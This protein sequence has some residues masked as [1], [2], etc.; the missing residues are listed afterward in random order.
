MI[1]RKFDKELVGEHSDVGLLESSSGDPLDFRFVV[2]RFQGA[3][4][5][6]QQVLHREL[7]KL[8]IAHEFAKNLLVAF[9]AV[10]D[11]SLEGFLE[12]VTE[13][14]FRVCRCGLF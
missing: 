3:I 14:L 6:V 9:H 8:S 2:T 4:H 10:D 5:S 7:P 1:M 11:E 13:V 12:Y